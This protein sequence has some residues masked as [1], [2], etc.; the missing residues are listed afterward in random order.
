[1]TGV[2]PVISVIGTGYLGATHAA[3]L[4]ELGFEVIGIDLDPVK[5]AALAT[6]VVPFHEPGLADL[7]SEHVGNGRLRFS[8]DVRDA[9][10]ADVHFLCVGTP[11]GHDGAA[12]LRQVHGAVDALVPAIKKPCLIVGK[13]TVP[14]GTAE[15]LRSR[16]GR[17]RGSDIEIEVAWNPEFLRE[18]H[19]VE[20]TLRPNRIVLGTTSRAAEDVLRRI[21][22]IPIS[23]GT[24][25]VVTDLATA[26]L[27]KMAANAFLATKIS[28]ANAMAELCEAGGADVVGLAEALGYDSRIGHQFLGAGLGFGGGCLPKDIRALIAWGESV[29]RSDSVAFLREVDAV[30]RRRR[31]RVVEMAELTLGSVD[32][33]RIGVLGA[34][35]KPGSDDVRDS[36]ALE[37]AARLCD[38]GAKVTVYD[39]VANETSQSVAPGLDYAGEAI[40]ACRDADLVLH[41]TDWPEFRVLDPAVMG[42]VVRRKVIIDARNVLDAHAWQKAG[43]AVH[44]PGRR[45]DELTDPVAPSQSTASPT[46]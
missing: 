35:F 34:A 43:W 25:V 46:M 45:L 11:Q 9:A 16:I 39:P 23:Q 37:V 31:D 36:P 4:A 26:E 32:D 38:A 8:T 14:V 33:K 19:G 42:E 1:V 10:D 28:F 6:G 44:A 13:S 5:I 18:G 30:N 7:I 41:L 3:G 40:D 20:D 15:A 27:T 17:L 2:A 22:T 24:P 12:D 21:Y 29:E